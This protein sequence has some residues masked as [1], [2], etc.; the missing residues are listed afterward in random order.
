ML[1]EH[2]K[3]LKSVD[4][5]HQMSLNMA[6]KKSVVFLIIVLTEVI[7]KKKQKLLVGTREQSFELMGH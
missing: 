3:A 7:D 1:K 5:R 2:E 6:I 4:V